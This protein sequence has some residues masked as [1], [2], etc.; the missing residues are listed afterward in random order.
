MHTIIDTEWRLEHCDTALYV[1]GYVIL[2]FW[3]SVR[4]KVTIYPDVFSR[5]RLAAKIAEPF[6][7]FYIFFF[8]CGFTFCYDGT[9]AIHETMSCVTSIDR[10]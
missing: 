6:F 5:Y 8:R 2:A 7:I 9:S 10:C 1:G 3:P 4:S